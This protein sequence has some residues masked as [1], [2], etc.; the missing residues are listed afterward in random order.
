ML[1]FRYQQLEDITPEEFSSLGLFA[2]Y[3]A[4]SHCNY[5]NSPGQAITCVNNACPLVQASNAK[6]SLGFTYVV[7]RT[8]LPWH[9]ISP[10]PENSSEITDVAGYIGIDPTRSLI[11]LSFRGSESIENWITK[12]NLLSALSNIP[13]YFYTDHSD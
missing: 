5:A 9:S 3:A 2:Q 10:Q 1:T 6:T 12:Y 11:I 4:A 13:F 7:S 8:Q